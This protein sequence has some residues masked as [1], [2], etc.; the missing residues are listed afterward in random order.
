[1]RAMFRTSRPVFSLPFFITLIC[2]WLAVTAA[3]F[4]FVEQHPN[5][6]WLFYAALPACLLEATFY[7]AATFVETRHALSQISPPRLRALLLWSSALL[8]YLVFS[9]SAHTFQR[10]AFLILLI[11]TALLSFWYV[12]TPRRFVYDAAFLVIAA[13]PV[14]AHL[15]RRIYLVPDPKVQLDILGHVMWIRIGILALLVLRPWDPGAFSLWP[16]LKEWKFGLLWY[17]IALLPICALALYLHDA[18]LAPLDGQ[19]LLTAAK[20][21]GT[22]FGIL[23]V[24]ALSEELFFRGFITRGLLRNGYSPALAI[25]VSAV[26]FG[27]CHLWFH[28]FPNWRRALVAT[29]LGLACGSAYVQTRSVRAPMVTHAL[30]VTTWRLFFR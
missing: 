1:M 7:L 6:H 10:N 11:F 21:V 22:F 2:V 29:V 26:L 23:W 16:Q 8:P 14:I 28:A 15:F 9:L 24:V 19:P 27:A 12:V 4:V 30:I 18:Q 20:G 5:D 3:S 17:A 25:V 13:A